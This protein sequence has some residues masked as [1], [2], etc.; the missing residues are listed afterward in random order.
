MYCLTCSQFAQLKVVAEQIGA[1]V[2]GLEENI[3][4]FHM[5]HLAVL[6]NLSYEDLHKQVAAPASF[7]E[8]SSG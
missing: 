6:H 5:W 3:N 8:R 2:P 4:A 7:D 1:K